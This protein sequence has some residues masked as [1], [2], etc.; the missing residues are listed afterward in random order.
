MRR[1]Q[2]RPKKEGV[3]L[4][5]KK[6][7]RPKYGNQIL[8]VNGLKFAS[9]KEYERYLFL[10]DAEFLGLISNLKYQVTFPLT[11]KQCEYVEVQLKTKTKRVERV[12]ERE[13]TYIADFVYEK[14][15]VTVV[16]DCKI[17]KWLIPKEFVG[18]RKLML[19]IYGIKVRQV[20][21]P[22]ESV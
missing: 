2:R 21:S 11:P 1:Y 15:G 10:K 5:D 14:N 20:Y 18:K 6:K 8:E 7:K 22:T 17:S 4:E 3:N 19:Y 9:K 16:E 12:V 13:M